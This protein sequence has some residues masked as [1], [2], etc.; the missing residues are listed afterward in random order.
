MP[1]SQSQH[2]APSVDRRI[3]LLGAGAG[4]AAI[5]VPSVALA[6]PSVTLAAADDRA[7]HLVVLR[8]RGGFDGISALPSR[9]TAPSERPF[10][11]SLPLERQ[12]GLHPSLGH[13]HQL[14]RR[15]EVTAIPG[16]GVAGDHPSPGPRG[17]RLAGAAPRGR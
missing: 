6:A 10:A 4:L 16:L 15:G 8:L 12:I 1:M 17:A 2:D 13:L 9:G 5:A 3:F 14:F 7:R 11:M